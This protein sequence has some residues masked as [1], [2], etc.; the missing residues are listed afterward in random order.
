MKKYRNMY[1]K[2]DVSD[3]SRVMAW[4]RGAVMWVQL[5]IRLQKKQRQYF[6][7]VH[8]HC[9]VIIYPSVCVCVWEPVRDHFPLCNIP[10]YLPT[11][12]TKTEQTRT[13]FVHDDTEWDSHLFPVNA[14]CYTAKKT[15]QNKKINVEREVTDDGKHPKCILWNKYQP[16]DRSCN[17]NWLWP[18]YS[19]LNFIKN[20]SS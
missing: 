17:L 4:R 13:G 3:I 8:K 7:S 9:Y 16:A 19:P 18:F 10:V 5:I 1:K 12:R 14:G 11:V 6:Q 15:K 20:D 2:K